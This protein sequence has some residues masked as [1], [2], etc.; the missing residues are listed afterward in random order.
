LVC[1]FIGILILIFDQ[2]V[3]FNRDPQDGPE[4]SANADFIRTVRRGARVITCQFTCIFDQ[5]LSIEAQIDWRRDARSPTDAAEKASCAVF[6]RR[7]P[8]RG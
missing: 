3:K 2:S 5:R 1:S 4:K 7:P 6:Q 8:G